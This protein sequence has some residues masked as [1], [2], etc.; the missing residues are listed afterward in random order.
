MTRRRHTLAT[1]AVILTGSWCLLP[2]A[3]HAAAADQPATKAG[4][5]FFE[6]KIRPVLIKHCY[7]CHSGQAKKLQA[8][9]RL[10]SRILIRKGGETG[11][12][13]VPG[14]PAKSLLLE[15]IKYES[16][17][18]PPSG[19]LPARVI[20]DF[21]T[22]IKLGAPDPRD[23]VPTAKGQDKQ[24]GMSF[25]TARTWWS[26]Q[27]LTAQPLPQVTTPK[28][29]RKRLDYFVL[30]RL[31]QHGLAPSP[32]ADRRT[33]LRRLKLDLIGL[34]PT[35]QE[36]AEYEGDLK[37]GATARLVDRFLASRHYGER[38]G[39]HWLDVARWAEDNPTSEATNR[40]H[41]DA[42]RYRDWVFESINA[43]MPYD[44]FLVMQLA[45]DLL[46]GFERNDLRALGYLGTAPTYHKDPRLSKT[47]IET[48]AT[49]DWDERVDALSRGL[50]ALTVACARCHRHKFDAITQEDYYA[51]SGV[52][53]SNWKVKRPLVD[54]TPEQE[55]RVVWAQDR[56]WRL[57][58]AISLKSDP[59][60]P[61]TPEEIAAMKAER[62]LLKQTPF[63]D[64]PATPAVYDA[65]VHVD[66]TDQDFTWMDFR[67]GQPR[68]L[69]VFLRGNVATP[70]PTAHRRF[71]AVL[72]P[73]Q[74][75]VAYGAGSG[76]LALA[77]SITT[78]AAPLAARVFV[79][80][81]WGW[82]FGR[83]L[84]TTA[85]DFGAQGDRP[86]HPQLL[87][88]LAAGFIK[89][90]W[91]LKWLH[92]EILLSATYAQSSR[93]RQL[94]AEQDPVN[95]WLWRFTP[96]RVDF[97]T[98]RDAILSVT[99]SL[100][101][102]Y[103]GPSQDVS[104]ENNVRRTVYAT[105][106]RRQVSPLMRLY[107]FPDVSQHV[108]SRETTTTPLQQLFVFNSPFFI[109]QAKKLAAYLDADAAD[110]AN[111]ETLYRRVFSR[112]PTAEETKLA[113]D[114]LKK[115]RMTHARTAWIDYCHAL[116]AT[117]ELIFVD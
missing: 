60:T 23:K 99:G 36:I 102:K 94:P 37:P 31:E 1:V 27:P 81:V 19:K 74:K 83:A 93:L 107:D 17:E 64:A 98:W 38:W 43:D 41:P 58:V 68:D 70:G 44:R 42:W 56:I 2:G 106:S 39:R 4:I 49:D 11:V 3:H 12:A 77:R 72:S 117:S 14:Q 84:V 101:T 16:L 33:L 111:V 9:F 108:P 24:T 15:A 28:W 92:R 57:D 51:L 76:R 8:K 21:E 54:L 82:H 87:D 100:D 69:P 13:I 103:L 67:V 62:E 90:G 59:A 18:M 32:T 88:D 78:T 116:L 110:S 35:E 48:I 112:R 20:A 5:A 80:R 66:N 115:R 46:P 30:A 96:H 85:S 113:T 50:L 29:A 10:D 104:D 34:P 63:L 86:S 26:Y 6:Q 45:A 97:E 105:V 114:F 79:N 22:W 95:R 61:S 89:N 109:R 65:A 75:P 73:E 40:P 52:F 7:G 25:E 91:S 53:A 47:V 55:R 71:L